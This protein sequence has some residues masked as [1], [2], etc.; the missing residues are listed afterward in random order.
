MNEQEKLLLPLAFHV[1]FAAHR[2]QNDGVKKGWE[3]REIRDVRQLGFFGE[4]RW[5]KQCAERVCIV[6]VVVLVFGWGANERN[7]E[8]DECHR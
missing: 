7:E 2:F 3:G 4:A 6:V 1:S 5:H 8:D